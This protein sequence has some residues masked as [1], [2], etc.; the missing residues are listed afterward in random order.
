MHNIKLAASNEYNIYNN[1]KKKIII[2]HFKSHSLTIV[3]VWQ[4][5]IAK[6]KKNQIK[7]RFFTHDSHVHRP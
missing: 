3:I 5:E 4:G 1:Y 2:L 6:G 7:V